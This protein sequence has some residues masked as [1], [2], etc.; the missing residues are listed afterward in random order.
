MRELMAILR[1]FRGAPG[2][3]KSSAARQMF[4]GTLLLEN[5]MYHMHDGVYDWHAES[6]KHAISWCGDMAKTALANNI[7]V[8]VANTF[9]KRKFIEFYQK[10]AETHKAKFEVYRCVGHFK[11]VHGL[12]DE[13]VKKFEDSMEDWPGE[14]ILEPKKNEKMAC[15]VFDLSTD[16]VYGRFPDLKMADMFTAGLEESLAQQVQVRQV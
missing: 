16:E 12:S 11:N 2:G 15:E 5:D 9:T 1:I 6:M 13:M 8:I 14:T 10:L 3:G 4:P 7:D